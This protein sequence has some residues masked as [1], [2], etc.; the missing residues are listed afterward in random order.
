MGKHILF[1]SNTC[2]DAEYLNL[3]RIKHKEKMNASQKFY[4][5]F[6]AGLQS[7]D[8]YKITFLTARNVDSGNCKKKYLKRKVEKLNENWEYVYL[9]VLNIKIIKKI[10]FF[11]AAFFETLRQKPDE[12]IFD[13][14]AYD[15][16]LG[17]SL[18]AKFLRCPKLG[19]YTDLP[20]YVSTNNSLKARIKKVIRLFF[21]NILIRDMDKYCFL[22][23]SMNEI[24]KHNKPY[25]VIEG[26]IPSDGLQVKDNHVEGNTVVYAGS[27]NTE[28]GID[29]LVEAAKRIKV[30][31]FKLCLC[32]DGPCVDLIKQASVEYPNIIYGGV[33]PLSEI[34]VLERKAKLLINPRPSVE[35]FTKYSFPSKTLEY[36]STGR[37]VL[38]TRLSGIPQEYY[39]YIFPLEDES[40]EGIVKGITAILEMD[41]EI[42][43]KKGWEALS[44]V[45]KNKTN[46]IQGKRLSEF[47]NI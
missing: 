17:V 40:V 1:V 25:V 41:N 27:L 43:D 3:Q 14:L 8:N 5:M 11:F 18:A 39:N 34:V 38:S 10:R 45:E 42:L 6:M 37:P 7:A 19:I 36:M 21:S 30:P 24:N 13:P 4:S 33:V 22:T 2:S 47:M 32:G 46:I 44:F 31:G 15:I 35:D 28:C 20:S 23:E 9:S 12:I 26:M 29:R 16:S